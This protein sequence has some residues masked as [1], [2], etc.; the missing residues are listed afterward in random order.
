MLVTD[1][2]QQIKDNIRSYQWCY[3]STKEN[4][5]D[6][7]SRGVNADQLSSDDCWFQG[8]SFLWQGKKCWPSKNANAGLSNNNPELKRDISF[9]NTLQFFVLLK[10]SSPYKSKLSSQE[11]EMEY[12]SSYS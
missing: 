11:K 1:R 8:P 12:F 9:C 5:V 2:V 3:I 4:P 10:L 7:A 6:G